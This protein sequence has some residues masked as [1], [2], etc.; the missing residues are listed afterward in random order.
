MNGVSNTILGGNPGRDALILGGLDKEDAYLSFAGLVGDGK[1]FDVKDNIE[2]RLGKQAYLGNDWYEFSTTGNILY[3]FY[4]MAAGF[5]SLELHA[6]AG[7]AQLNDAL[8]GRDGIGP[9]GFDTEG[10]YYAIEFGI[11]LYNNYFG[12]GEL[13]TEEFLAALEA[14]EHTDKMGHEPPPDDY[15]YVPAPEEY[16]PDEFNQD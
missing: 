15:E 14:F 3:G 9:Y 11:F 12:D 1:K 6:G 4:G 16:S 2:T 7:Y 13:T 10:D 5:S 8:H